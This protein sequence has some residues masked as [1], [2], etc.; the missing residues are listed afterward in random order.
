MANTILD[1]LNKQQTAPAQ[2]AGRAGIGAT[3][4]IQQVIN[5]M[6]GGAA[7]TQA[8]APAQNLL[9]QRAVGDVQSAARTQ[10]AQ[11]EIQQAG[12]AEAQ[13]AQQQQFQ[14]QSAQLGEREQAVADR[15]RN[16]TNQLLSEAEQQRGQLDLAK[17]RAKAEQIGFNLRLSND[18]YVKRL[19]QEGQLRRLG[20]KNRFE[21]ETVKSLFGKEQ[22]LFKDQLDFNESLNMDMLQWEEELQRVDLENWVQAAKMEA[23]AASSK[24]MAEGV[25]GAFSSGSQFY[26]NKDK[27]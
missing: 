7:A 2:Q 13:A 12:L 27:K 5:Q 10:Q 16:Q 17:N 21:E 8:P 15:A 3:S 1:A 20:D 14:Q 24:Q 11:A 9:E 22:E 23:K 18:K 25:Q 6:R 4:K 26:A 19:Q